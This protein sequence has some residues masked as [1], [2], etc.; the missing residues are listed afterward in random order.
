[1]SVP[2]SE[3][4]DFIANEV[5]RVLK[6]KKFSIFD[7]LKTVQVETDSIITQLINTYLDNELEGVLEL[8]SI[9]INPKN[10]IEFMY[11]VK[12]LDDNLAYVFFTE[13]YNAGFQ[14]IISS[15]HYDSN[16]E[17]GKIIEQFDIEGF[18]YYV[19]NESRD[20]KFDFEVAFDCKT[21]DVFEI[22]RFNDGTLI[23]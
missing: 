19:I 11:E 10:Q 6:Y 7:Q 12:F 8:E 17:H 4:Q 20:W 5:K 3:E 21:G 23:E 2:Y 22:N 16:L 14:Y 13:T 15:K 9:T 1:P 18:Y